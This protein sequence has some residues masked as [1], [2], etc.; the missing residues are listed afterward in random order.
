MSISPQRPETA[1]KTVAQLAKE[2]GCDPID[3]ICDHLIADNGATRVLITSI[4]EDDIRTII[5]S[6]T[7]LVGS[8]AT[9]SPI[10]ARS[11]FFSAVALRHFSA[12]DRPPC[13]T[14]KP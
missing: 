4:S 12:G 9:A 2:S 7:A 3:Q 5:R 8:T 11:F 13:L 1:G 10:T 14:T 6:P